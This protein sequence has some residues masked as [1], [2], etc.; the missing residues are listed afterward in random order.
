MK[1]SFNFSVF[2]SSQCPLGSSR[3]RR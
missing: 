3:I 2:S 1:V